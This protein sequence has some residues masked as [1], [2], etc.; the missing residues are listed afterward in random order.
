[1]GEHFYIFHL[2][3]HNTLTRLCISKVPWFQLGL[4]RPDFIGRGPLL[5]SDFAKVLNEEERRMAKYVTD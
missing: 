4:I 5:E 2:A 3:H 1:M